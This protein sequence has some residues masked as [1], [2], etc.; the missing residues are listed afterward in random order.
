MAQGTVKK[1]FFFYFGLFFLLIFAVFMVCLVI[2]MFNPGK[3]IL[4]MQYF[5]SNTNQY[6][7]KDSNG[8]EI[9]YASINS[10]KINCD[11]A[12]VSVVSNNAEK[13]NTKGG[14]I[15]IINN[16]KGFVVAKDAKAFDYKVSLSGGALTIDIVENTGFLFFS[17]DVEVVI[18]GY[19]NLNLNGVSLSVD[20]SGASDVYFGDQTN[21]HDQTF[22][23]ASA[24]IKTANGSIMFGKFFKTE[25]LGGN[26]VFSSNTGRITSYDN[27]A[28]FSG[29][30]SL[31][32][33]TEKGRVNFDKTFTATGV[34]VTLKN[35]NGT[36]NFGTFTANSVDVYCSQ[37]NF[38]FDT[39]TVTNGISFENSIDTIISPIVDI[40]TLNGDLN[41]NATGVD[42][43]SSPTLNIEVMNGN[44][45]V[46]SSKGAV[47]IKEAKK[48]VYIL[49]QTDNKD[50]SMN[51][52]VNVSDGNT[53]FIDITTEKGKIYLGY[54]GAV[55]SSTK[56]QTRNGDITINFT[57]G[58]AFTTTAKNFDGSAA[59]A[60]DRINTN[61]KLT[62]EKKSELSYGD[63]ATGSIAVFTDAKLYY[64]LVKEVK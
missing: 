23:L 39:L 26:A 31:S 41:L 38:K 27:N 63:S 28:N 10:V 49:S 14:G 21:I 12:K 54:I 33:E 35:K 3:T 56:L 1:G 42:G 16:A 46:L 25:S 30:T 48:K 24:N 6:V 47:N 13:N 9:D 45:D 20:A 50:G 64:N 19:S 59:L 18:N 7:E 57:T 44:L 40:K 62:D 22:S 53:E 58:A 5:T 60:E 8:A 2:M 15:Y 29:V 52:N 36:M 55:P 32:I 43:V 34:D 11:Y 61:P 4:W 17:K 51:V 37:G